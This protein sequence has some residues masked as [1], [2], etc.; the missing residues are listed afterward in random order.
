MR[1][2]TAPQAAESVPVV[3]R[4]TPFK[5]L[6]EFLR[7]EEVAAVL[8]CRKGLVYALADRGELRSVRFGRL[9]RVPRAALLELERAG[10]GAR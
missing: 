7:A 1:D 5:D 9:L 8:G 6:P 3:T 10:G 4:A 2:E